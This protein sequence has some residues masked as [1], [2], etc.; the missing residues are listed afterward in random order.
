MNT[1]NFGDPEHGQPSEPE[2]L[3]AAK[4]R[5]DRLIGL[6]STVDGWGNLVYRTPTGCPIG[7]GELY[8][9]PSGEFRIS[10]G[11]PVALQQEWL[12]QVGRF[13]EGC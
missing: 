12:R 4:R 6:E 13:S 9:G 5:W 1:T 2:S 8:E 11:Q 10:L 3:E 7:H